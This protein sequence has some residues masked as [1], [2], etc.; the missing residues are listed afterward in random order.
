MDV[1]ENDISVTTYLLPGVSQNE[2]VVQIVQHTNALE[3]QMGQC[4]IHAFCERSRHQGQAEGQDL[5]L[6]SLRSAHQ[7]SRGG[8]DRFERGERV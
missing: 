4:S 3:P 1:V 6:V 5:V 2:P 8:C 7:A